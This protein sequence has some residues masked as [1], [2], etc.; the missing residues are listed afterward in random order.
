MNKFKQIF[1]VVLAVAVVVAS[2]GCGKAIVIKGESDGVNSHIHY[3]GEEIT[4]VYVDTQT[5][6]TSDRTEQT[7]SVVQSETTQSTIVTTTEKKPELS[8]TEAQTTTLQTSTTVATEPS[9]ESIQTTTPSTSATTI[10][11]T[12][13]IITTT[14]T[15]KPAPVP[16]NTDLPVNNYQALNHAETKGVWISYFELYPILTGK[17]KSTFAKGIGE[18]YDKASAL[19]LNTVYVHV[20]PFGDAIYKSDYYPWSKYCTG[21][22]GEDPGYDPLEVMIEEAHKRNIS[23]HAWVNPLRCSQESDAPLIDDKYLV[24]QW[25]NYNDGDYI[26][27]VSSYW[28]LNPAYDEVTDLIADGVAELVSRYD[29]DGVHIDDYFYPTKE[30]WFDNKSFSESG[31]SD[32]SQFRLDNCTK[33]VYKMYSAVKSHNSSALFGVSAQG[34]VH[35]N[36]NELYAD[37]EKWSR[38]DGYVDYMA[39]QIYYGFENGGQ[40]YAEVVDQWDEML[41]GTGKKLIPGLAVYKIGTED[42]WAGSGKYEWITEKQIIK[43]QIEKARTADN[44]S[45]IIL[46][47]YQFIFSPESSVEDAVNDEIEAIKPLLS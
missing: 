44:Y 39:P 29:V 23:F 1:A 25:Y 32:L 37:V 31:Y 47:S 13:T 41:R 6:V 35:N 17:S 18:Y 19:G 34:N 36:I 26:S 5:F 46:Y 3:D 38:E 9:S 2:A 42:T 12:T 4:G 14:T 7:S 43:R 8:T 40:P 30:S 45:G 28:Y 27:K 22:I 24:K 10:T 20:R 21:Y 33:M 11:T 16:D 15:V